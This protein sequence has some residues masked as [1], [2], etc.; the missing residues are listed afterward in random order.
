MFTFNKTLSSNFLTIFVL[1]LLVVYFK[2]FYYVP[3]IEN[4]GDAIKYYKIG[5]DVSNLD[6]SNFDKHHFYLRW[7]VWINSL[8]TNILFPNNF[9]SYYLS[10]LIPFWLGI[11]VYS[12][13]LFKETG[14]FATIFFLL[15]VSSDPD[16]TRASYQLLPMGAAIL[17]LALLTLVS[18][19]FFYKSNEINITQTIYVSFLSF[20]LFSI[21]ETFLLFALLFIIIAFKINKFKYIYIFVLSFLLFYV[22]ET[23]IFKLINSDYSIFGKLHFFVIESTELSK[24]WFEKSKMGKFFDNGLFSRWYKGQLLASQSVIFFTSF[25]FS[26]L[27]IFKKNKDLS[28]QKI[29]SY[30]I[31][32]FFILNTLFIT[33]IFPLKPGLPHDSRFV[34][35]IIPICLILIIIFVYRNL[36]IKNFISFSILAFVFINFISVNIYQAMWNYK[37]FEFRYSSLIKKVVFY[38]NFPERAKNNNCIHSKFYKRLH[39]HLKIV[40]QFDEENFLK[41]FKNKKILEDGKSFV[42]KSDDEKCKEIIIF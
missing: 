23:I 21:R 38:N 32:L 34:A 1:V 31:F 19:K 33:S 6:F 40:H 42:I 41:K 30:F 17:P 18:I 26:L 24:L 3:D 16:L 35:P 28:V 37:Y 10:S 27:Y 29:L 25:I 20:W 8:I 13:I 5:I 11:L 12:K 15:I 2:L 9:L 4:G 36:E 14:I 39:Y 7:G 22:I